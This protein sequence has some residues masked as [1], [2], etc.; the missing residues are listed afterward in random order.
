MLTFSAAVS[1]YRPLPYLSG[2][3]S[4]ITNKLTIVFFLL[5]VRYHSYLMEDICNEDLGCTHQMPYEGG[6]AQYEE[7]C[8]VKRMGNHQVKE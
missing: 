4:K 6:I 2:S 1:G 7:G 3:Q 8:H 5:C